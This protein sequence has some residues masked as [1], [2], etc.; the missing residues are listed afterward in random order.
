MLLVYLEMLV[1]PAPTMGHN[2]AGKQIGKI[3]A[4]S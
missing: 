4:G 2:Q 1:F 3:G